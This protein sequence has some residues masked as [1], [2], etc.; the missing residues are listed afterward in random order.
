MMGARRAI[1]AVLLAVPLLC[2]CGGHPRIIPGTVLTDIY[3]EMLL[4][5]Q[6]LADH[7]E[8]RKASDTTLFYDPI[9]RRYGYTY[10]D[11]DATV[12]RYLED[13]EKF[14]KVFKNASMKLKDERDRYRR[15]VEQLDDVREFNAS[16]KGYSAK[17]FRKD[18]LMLRSLYKDSLLRAYA[19]ARD[20]LRLDSLKSAGLE[21]EG[22]KPDSLSSEL[23]RL[24][25]LS[26][27]PLRP[28]VLK[29][30]APRPDIRRPDAPK[31]DSSEPG[32]RRPDALKR[33]SSG[34]DILKVDSL[35]PEP[36]RPS[37]KTT[38]VKRQILNKDEIHREIRV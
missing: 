5:D 28:D 10:E 17:D 20:S 37:E 2:S 35:K 29:R 30:D 3:A 36:R 4:A 19:M 14:A 18:T 7:S 23:L 31:Q 27:E 38:G 6:W 15:K 22:L 25:T 33:D 34:P 32:S 21:S 13:P 12:R 1:S 16:I 24:D 11:Y 8:A 26:A 9:F